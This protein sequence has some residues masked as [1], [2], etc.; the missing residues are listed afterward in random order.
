MLL[1][2]LQRRDRVEP[3]DQQHRRPGGEGDAQ[4][5]VEPEDVVHRQQAEPHVVRPGAI[6]RRGSDLP[7]V[8]QQ[9]AV[10]EH[11]GPWRTGGARGVH[12]DRQV[13]LGTLQGL[14]GG[15]V[16]EVVEARAAGRGETGADEELESGGVL[17][18]EVTEMPLGGGSD[19][20]GP[21][22]HVG[23]LACQRRTW[24]LRVERDR[25]RTHTQDGEVAH[26]EVPVVGRHD[27]DPVTRVDAQA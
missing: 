15:S 17:G 25:D 6:L 22:G 7:E 13:V 4:D 27:R 2:R 9:V 1:D 24:G 3:L 21:D 16:H 11:R 12:E 14:S 19:D 10:G 18:G 26:H 5:H 8:H 20:R 23:H